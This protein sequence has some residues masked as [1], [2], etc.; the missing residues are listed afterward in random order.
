MWQFTRKQ[1]RKFFYWRKVICPPSKYIS[2]SIL[3]TEICH[4]GMNWQIQTVADCIHRSG[5]LQRKSW[6]GFRNCLP[7]TFPSGV[8]SC[9]W[10]EHK[11]TSSQLF[12]IT[13]NSCR[14]SAPFSGWKVS[15]PSSLPMWIFELPS[16]TKSV[17]EGMTWLSF[18][19]KDVYKRQVHTQSNSV[20]SM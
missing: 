9:R 3:P 10:E 14:Q 16:S 6:K 15:K 18:I 12:S 5:H 1:K 4:L 8:P 17:S 20:L 13:V 2:S 11:D 19:I 7:G